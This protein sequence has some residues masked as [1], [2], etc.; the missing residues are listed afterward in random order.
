MSDDIKLTQI[1]L[2]SMN[3]SKKEFECIYFSR[4]FFC[5]F[6]LI[7]LVTCI[8][9][10]IWQ[11]ALHLHKNLTL[12][13]V[14][15]FSSTKLFMNLPLSYS[16]WVLIDQ[17]EKCVFMSLFIALSRKMMLKGVHN[18]TLAS[19]TFSHSLFLTFLSFLTH[20]LSLSDRCAPSL[21]SFTAFS[22]VVAT[23]VARRQYLIGKST[24]QFACVIVRMEA[25]T[26]VFVDF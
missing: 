16:N 21:V 6:A 13:R 1:Y 25:W 3:A 8:Y 23:A 2:L 7:F 26:W 15:F 17:C 11:S 12:D 14:F 4:L 24:Y 9:L 19:I 20:S 22:V 10:F 18:F 5:L